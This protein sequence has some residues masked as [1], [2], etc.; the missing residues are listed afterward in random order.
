MED[1]AIKNGII[2]TPHGKITGGLTISGH[3]ISHIG[4]DDSL[5]R[6]KQEINA[7]GFVILPGLIDPHVHLGQD[8][9]EK[10]RNQC[11]S[12]S[13]SAVLGGITTLITTVRFGNALEHRLNT[14]RKAKEIAHTN[15]FIDFKFNAYMTNRKHLEEVEGLMEEGINSFKLMMGYTHNEA[16]EIGLE[17]IDWGFAYK[18]FEI[19]AKIG[20]PALAMIHCE[21]PEIIHVL[22]QRLE[23][24]KRQDIAAWT[25]SRPSICETMQ[26]FNAGL[27]AQELGTPV[28]IV[29][30]SANE[31]VDALQYF[32][33]AK[34][35]LRICGETCP[36]YLFLDRNANCGVLGKVNPPLRNLHDQ[37]RLW[38][39][40]HEGILDTVGSDHVVN[41][42]KDKEAGGLWKAKLGFAGMGA[43]LSLLVSEGVNKGK[44]TWE[45]L[46]KI[47]SENVAKIFHI[48]PKK[49]AIIPGSDAD[50][51]IVDPQREWVLGA[52]SLQSNSDF[53]VYEGKKVKGRAWKTFVRGQLIAEDGRL[54]AERPIG[55]YV[56]TSW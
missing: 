9:E 43:T 25:E 18:L 23:A 35:G 45:Q 5:P 13:F 54:V 6:A 31:S 34:S 44:L 37:I 12:E 39:G 46:A 32:K 53:S 49:G 17:E 26:V 38:Q 4:D 51:V 20:P 27:L 42:R 30:V 28:Y 41:F 56:F 16:R 24:E 47:S 52:G 19:V 22:R 36:H 14:Y 3:K 8:E 48:Y 11:R 10:F 29:H 21:E 50:I 55:E 33:K 15:S 2:I 7:R 40:L 1:L